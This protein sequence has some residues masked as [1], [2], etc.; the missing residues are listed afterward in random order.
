MNLYYLGPA[1]SFTEEAAKNFIEEAMYIPCSSI[2]DTLAAVKTNPNSLCVVPVENSLEGTVLRTLDLILEKNLR[3]IAEIDLLISQNLL[4]KEKTLSAIQTVYS[5]QHAIA[6]CRVWLK[7]HLPN[8]EYKETS[9]TSYA[10]ELVSKMPGAAAIS[11]LHAADLY[12][13]NVLGS[14]INN[15]AHNLTRFWLVTKMTHTALPIWTNRTPTKTSLYIVLKDKVGALR[16]LLET[17]AKNNVS[18][19]FIESR[20]LAS[21]PWCYGFFIDILVDAS[22]PFAR[23]MFAALKKEHLKAHLIGTYPQDRA[24]NKKSTIAR[25]LKRIEHIFEKNRRSPL[26][27]TILDEARNEWH[28]YQQTPRRVQRLLDTR[29]LLI[30]SIAL[31]KYKSG[32]GL[33]DRLRERALLQKTRHSA[34]LHLLYGELFKRSKQTQ[35]KII[36]LIK[37]KSILSEDILK[38]SLNDVR[39]YIDY[40]DTLIIQ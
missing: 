27:R 18:L 30:P 34:I 16:D 4:S 19:T 31:N 17:F 7:K 39:Y 6:Q 14:H 9:S 38:L 23:K 10:A 8:A 28:N 13:L 1:G 36:R 37:T 29:F 26:I 11:S 12:H 25:N 32:D 15:H 22:D 20:P 2:E 40:I 21:K 3:V 5:H 35:E 33:T 24:Y